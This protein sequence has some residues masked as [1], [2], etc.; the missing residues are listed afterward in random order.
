MEEEMKLQ[1]QS[2][3]VEAFTRAGWKGDRL[4]P[5]VLNKVYATAV[6]PK[7]A[8]VRAYLGQASDLVWLNGQY[9]S[10]GRNVL[11]TCHAFIPSTA[12][13]VEIISKVETFLADVELAISGTYAVR[14]LHPHIPGQALEG[15]VLPPESE[16]M[17]RG[18]QLLDDIARETRAIEN[19]A[20][21]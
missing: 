16:L 14:L 7:E 3:A 12:D 21:R 20:R 18:R 10:E 2:V 8:T 11:A 13:E 6:G 17:S 1:V 15:E 4:L 5:H 9:W 19:I